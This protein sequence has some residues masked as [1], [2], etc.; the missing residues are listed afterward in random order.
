MSVSE[1]GQF[2]QAREALQVYV[3]DFNVTLNTAGCPFLR[4]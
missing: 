1:R 3:A 4:L 2:A